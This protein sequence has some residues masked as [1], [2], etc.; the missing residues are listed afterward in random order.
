MLYDL[1]ERAQHIYKVLF[2]GSSMHRRALALYDLVARVERV[3]LRI[4]HCRA[5][6][7]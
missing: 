5:E 6:A 1:V 2:C 3:R 4:G 7:C